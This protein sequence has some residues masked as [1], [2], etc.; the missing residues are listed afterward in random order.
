[1][2]ANV[3]YVC[4]VYVYVCKFMCICMY[5]SVC[6]WIV[7]SVCPVCGVHKMVCVYV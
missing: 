4:D 7:C 6:D 1:M 2:C 3:D 5:V